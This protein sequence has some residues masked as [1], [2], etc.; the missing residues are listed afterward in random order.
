MLIYTVSLALQ[1][2]ACLTIQNRCSNID[3]VS[4]V[5]FGNGV[6]CP[7]LSDQQLD[8]YAT[9]RVQFEI[10][11]TQDEFVGVLL[12]KLQR[13]S[14]SQYNMGTSIMEAN[15]NEI[16]YVQLLIAWEMKDSE[17]SAS[18]VLVEREIIWNEDELRKLYYENN[19]LLKKYN[20]VISDTWLM[21]DNMVLKTTC[22]VKNLKEN[23]ELSISISEERDCY[24]MRPLCIDP[25]R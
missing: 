15:T 12:Y 18:V 20:D 1:L 25:K 14:V 16:K 7:K 9:M 2:P 24:V 10:H 19:N 21:D 8:I 4:P 22:R 17:L 3:L 13:H 5:Y 23:F 11:T 6:V